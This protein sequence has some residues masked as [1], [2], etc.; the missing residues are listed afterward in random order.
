MDRIG[1]DYLEP[2]SAFTYNLGAILILD[3]ALEATLDYWHYRFDDVIDA[4]PHG[5]LVNLY[6]DAGNAA[7]HWWPR[8]SSV[9]RGAQNRIPRL[10]RGTLCGPAMSPAC[11]SRC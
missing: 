10:G 3:D 2:E 1:G 8:A 6:A 7:L 11:R 5:S 9:R 4:A